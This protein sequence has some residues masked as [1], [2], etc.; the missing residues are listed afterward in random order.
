MSDIE[1]LRARGDHRVNPVRFRLIEALARR[2]AAHEGEARRLLD[3]RLAQLLAAYAEDVAHRA[4]GA[5][6]AP[7]DAAPMQGGHALSALGAHIAQQAALRGDGPTAPEG[8]TLTWFRNVWTRLSA[9]R[10][11]VQSLEKVPTN[12]GPL[13]S[14][15]LVHQSL[16][17]M[18]DVS[19]EYLH[20]FMSYVDT[21]FWLDQTTAPPQRRERK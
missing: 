7:A 2:S 20:R 16:T 9:E 15:N 14:H 12:A 3:A 4:K 19:P 11:L 21:L 13:N 1:A 18:R 17:L 10:R 5:A 6:V 8:Q